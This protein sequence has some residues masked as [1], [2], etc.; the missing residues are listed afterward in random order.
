MRP[1]GTVVTPASRPDGPSRDERAVTGTASAGP[2][3]PAG[4]AT[5]RL[6]VPAPGT[7]S[8][9]APEP[10]LAGPTYEA[11]QPSSR[12]VTAGPRAAAGEMPAA[13]AVREAPLAA[14]PAAPSVDTTQPTVAATHAASDEASPPST[15]PAASAPPSGAA[16]APAPGPSGG[17]LAALSLAALTLAAALCF[18]RLLQ[19][20][21]H[22]RP[23]F[24]VSSIERPG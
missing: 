12:V 5:S 14:A 3:R 21:A 22:W 7:P 6:D 23:V 20:P 10:Q 19:P 18:T 13:S 17:A 16:G 4:V 1:T 24:V 2:S 15:A 9:I 8:T 11:P